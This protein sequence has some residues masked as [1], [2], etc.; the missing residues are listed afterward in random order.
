MSTV[1]RLASVHPTVYLF[2][3][4]VA[5]LPLQAQ[6]VTLSS[7]SNS[8]G[9]VVLGSSSA[10]S[11][12]TLR[13]GSRTAALTITGIAASGDFSQTNSCGSSLAARGSCS[14]RLIFTPTAG[15]TRTGTL[16]VTDNATPNTQTA[17]LTGNGVAPLSLSPTS[18][19]FGNVVVGAPAPPRLSP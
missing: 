8:F 4:L 16:T 9:D 17:S 2:L 5:S 13:N 1:R 6:I 19:A 12:L 7:T 15:G 11:T 14:I 18:R 3:L 10:A